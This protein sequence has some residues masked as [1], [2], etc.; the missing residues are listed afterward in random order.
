M[1]PPAAGALDACEEHLP[2]VP[3]GCAERCEQAPSHGRRRHPHARRC[4]YNPHCY[5]PTTPPSVVEELG[6]SIEEF[7]A[8]LERSRKDPIMRL[9][10]RLAWNARKKSMAEE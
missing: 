3:E 1:E 7:N 10:M 4:P 5:C 6:M 8:M 2:G 9:R